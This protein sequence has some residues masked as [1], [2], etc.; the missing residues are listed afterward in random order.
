MRKYFEN[1]TGLATGSDQVIKHS[2]NVALQYSGFKAEGII[3]DQVLIKKSHYPFRF[4]FQEA[5]DADY[6]VVCSRNPIDVSP[7]FFYMVLSLTH[8]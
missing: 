2:P 8:N 3:G 6:A 7:S 4:P 1:L 5:F